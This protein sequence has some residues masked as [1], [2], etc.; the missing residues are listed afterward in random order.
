MPKTGRN[1][2]CPCGSGKKF[3]RCCGAS[4]GEPSR[5]QIPSIPT[6]ASQ[7]NF[8]VMGLPAQTGELHVINR[9]LAGDPRNAMPLQGGEGH[10]KVSFVLARPGYNLLPENRYSFANRSEERRV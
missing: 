4:G 9:F 5:R 8:S 10:Y 3:K 6:S 2:A 7:I 1:D